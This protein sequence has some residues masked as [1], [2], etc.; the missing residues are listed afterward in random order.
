MW[1]YKRTESGIWQL[2]PHKCH[3]DDGNGD[4]DDY[5]TKDGDDCMY[6][7]VCIIYLH[8]APLLQ[9]LHWSGSWWSE[10][11][12]PSSHLP[13]PILDCHLTLQ[14]GW[15]SRSSPGSW[16]DAQ[17]HQ[18]L[19]SHECSEFNHIP[20]HKET[21]TLKGKVTRTSWDMGA[22][23][24]LKIFVAVFFSRAQNLRGLDTIAVI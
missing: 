24:Y 5:T 9:D 20:N 8:S 12:V 15:T 17:Y 18:V 4:D 23:R 7:N 13:T 16:V 6:T 22:L 1:K 3:P 14:S 11:C 2:S 19:M 10:L 21:L